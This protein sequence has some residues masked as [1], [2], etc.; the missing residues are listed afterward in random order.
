MSDSPAWILKWLSWKRW[1]LNM[2]Y[3]GLLNKYPVD[4]PLTDDER[5][6]QLHHNVRLKAS[7]I[8]QRAI[9]RINST[10]LE[11]LDK[12]YGWKGFISFVMLAFFLVIVW[13]IF[14][15]IGITVSDCSMGKVKDC[16][17]SFIL[18]LFVLL[19][20]L[21]IACVSIWMLR[22]ESFSYTHYPIRFNKKNG[23][24]YVFRKNATVLAI[25]W[26][27]VFFTLRPAQMNKFWEICGHV[28]DSDGVT[29]KETFALSDLQNYGYNGPE[30]VDGDISERN[31][32][33]RH[34]EFIRRY[35]E[36]GPKDLVNLV[37]YQRPV[38][39]RKETFFEG[40]ER[41]SAE[42]GG[43]YVMMLIG[44]P[45]I[46]IT[47]IGRWFAMRTSKIPVWPAEVEA[48]CRIDPDDPYVRE[49]TL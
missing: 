16:N 31:H 23:I 26:S 45:I 34:W 11:S 28:L 46:L 4:R 33:L 29:V 40:L 27:E 32:L 21:P 8:H 49:A 10:F 13:V 42:S 39:L 15:G 6:Y 37:D 7:P 38:H 44:S 18:M 41:V 12:Y 1:W 22:K 14:S 17:S 35:M 3:V 9:N 25:P 48:A 2:E 30:D 20:F 43:S 47:A 36:E 19:L 5:K 24:V